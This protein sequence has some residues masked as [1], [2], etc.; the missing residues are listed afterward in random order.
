MKTILTILVTTGLLVGCKTTRTNND[1]NTADY[2]QLA[3]QQSTA[4]SIRANQEAIRAHNESVAIHHQMQQDA[5]IQ[6]HH[7]AMAASLPPHSF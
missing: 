5:M 6:Q 1:Y 4:E 2:A 3:A 7:D